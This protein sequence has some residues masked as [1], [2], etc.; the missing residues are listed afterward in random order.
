MDMIFQL[1]QLVLF[2]PTQCSRKGYFSAS[3]GSKPSCQQVRLGE[4]PRRPQ[5]VTS[6]GLPSRCRD[7]R[8]AGPRGSWT[9]RVDDPPFAQRKLGLAASFEFWPLGEFWMLL[10]VVG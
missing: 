1:R 2:G 6:A 9:G 7:S 5:Q 4:G 3:P 8:G 10:G